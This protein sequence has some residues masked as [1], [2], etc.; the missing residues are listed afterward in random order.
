MLH[1]IRKMIGMTLTILR[2]FQKKSDIA[3]SFESTRVRA[4]KYFSA[5]LYSLQMDVPRA[6]GL[7]LILEQVHYHNYD[8]L[9]SKT[10]QT[11]NTFEPEIEQEIKRLREE[12]I[13]KEILETEVIS[14]QMMIWL[15]DLV[16]HDFQINAEAERAEQHGINKA[17]V[18]A[19]LSLEEQ[20]KQQNTEED[21]EVPD[22]EGNDEEP[23]AKDEDA[24]SEETKKAVA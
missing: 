16:K 20:G 22:N 4:L 5:N 24:E 14:N 8:K 15:S 23:V 21:E 6:P 18:T 7:G 3:R 13:I 1:Q 19:I 2:G 17:R 9:Y 10:H 11:L 12:L